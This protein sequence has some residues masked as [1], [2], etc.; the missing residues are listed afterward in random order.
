MIGSFILKTFL[1]SIKFKSKDKRIPFM[2]NKK[3]LDWKRLNKSLHRSNFKSSWLILKKRWWNKKNCSLNWRHSRPTSITKC[4]T[5]SASIKNLKKAYFC[6]KISRT[7]PVYETEWGLIEPDFW[8]GGKYCITQ[9]QLN[10]VATV[11]C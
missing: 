6:W 7:R 10:R 3:M 8:D 1:N 4:T 9:D 2:M 11:R 5:T